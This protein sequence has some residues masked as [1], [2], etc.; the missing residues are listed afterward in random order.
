MKNK[1]LIGRFLSI[2]ISILINIAKNI[3]ITIN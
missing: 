2:I 3:K 1:R